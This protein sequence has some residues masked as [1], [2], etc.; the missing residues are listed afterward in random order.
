MATTV[1]GTR[2]CCL[3]ADSALPCAVLPLSPAPL[4]CSDPLDG[5]L[6]VRYG[7]VG[8]VG[9]DHTDFFCSE[10]VAAA[11]QAL[12]VLPPRR[13]AASYWPCTCTQPAAAATAVFGVRCV[14]CDATP[15]LTWTRV[16]AWWQPTLQA[17][18]VWTRSLSTRRWR[19]RC[20][21]RRQCLALVLACAN[22]A[23][24]PQSRSQIVLDCKVMEV[25]RATRMV[26]FHRRQISTGSRERTWSGSS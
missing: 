21:C 12:A 19:M 23:F 8:D 22:C 7:G 4:A 2:P 3:P 16:D 15:S 25:R 10:L 13:V 14:R 18:A 26:D 20:V 1:M 17:G 11:Y 5:R 24:K 6:C 9:S